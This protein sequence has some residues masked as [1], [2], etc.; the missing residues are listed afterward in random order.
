MNEPGKIIKKERGWDI[1]IRRP[2]YFRCRRRFPRGGGE[3]TVQ[4][5]CSVVSPLPLHPA[6][7]ATF[8]YNKPK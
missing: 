1:S 3:P 5:C 6:G 7:V 8:R 4:L 2:V